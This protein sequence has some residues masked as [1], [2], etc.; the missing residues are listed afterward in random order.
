MA[1]MSG[2]DYQYANLETVFLREEVVAAAFDGHEEAREGEG[3][4][5]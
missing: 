1:K 2:N 5:T 3:L 4:V